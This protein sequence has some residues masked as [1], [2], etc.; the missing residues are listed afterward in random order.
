MVLDPKDREAVK[1][2]GLSPEIMESRYMRAQSLMQGL[3]SKTIAFNT[4]IIPRWIDNSDYFWYEREFKD[5]REFRLVNA[6]N[7]SNKLAFDH[8]KLAASLADASGQ[9]IDPTD[10]PITKLLFSSSLQRLEFDAFNTRWTFDTQGSICQTK[11][12]YPTEWLIS[13][14]GK[15]AA[16]V[17]DCNIWIHVLETNEE[18]QITRDGIPLYC[19]GST[20]SAYG[21]AAYS[22]NID[23]VWS[24]DS[25]RLL[26]LQLDMRLVKNLPMI[27]YVPPDGSLRP[28]YSSGDRRM[29]FPGDDHID[30]YRILSIDVRS[31]EQQDAHYRHC[32]VFRN[33]M[34][35][36][37]YQHGWWSEDS[38]HA[39]FIDMERNGDHVVRL[40]EFD[41]FTGATRLVITEES[42]DT[43]FKLRLDSRTPILTR[44]LS[45][46]N[47]VVWYSERS[48]WAHL[49]L[50]DLKTGQLK[51]AITSGEWL[52]RDILHYDPVLRELII[53]TAGR[54]K[55]RHAY[56]RDICRVNVDTG[57]L[58][59]IVSTNHEY[60]VFDEHSE[61]AMNLAGTR[62]VWGGFGVSPSGAYI[63]TTRSRA[64]EI[65]VSLLLDRDGNELF[66]L[67]T[68]DVSCLPDG[69]QWPEP[70]KLLGA[71]N[72]TDI[73]G[74]IYRPSHFSPEQ[75]YPILD[76]SLTLKEG[77]F[78]PAGSFTNNTIAGFLYFSAAALAELG[79]IVVDIYGRGTS[80]RER[81]FSAECCPEL[82]SSS[83]QADRISAIKQ[84]AEN[85]PYMDIER[86]GAGGMV[87]TSGAISG[88]LGHPDFYKVGVTNGAVS[89]LRVKSAFWGESYG[90]LPAS[91]DKYKPAHTYAKNLKGK[92]LIM[93]GMMH[94]SVPVANAFRLIDALQLANKDFDMLLLPNEGYAMNSYAIRRCWDYFVKELLGVEPPTQFKLTTSIDIITAHF[95]K[96]TELSR[97]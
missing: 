75:S 74:V 34:G 48:G 58:I 36:F 2:E 18:R 17:R 67:E 49:Y 72:K 51:N 40:V 68:A 19:Y 91:L 1:L 62:D 84:L 44:P 88:L 5:G 81:T 65:P 76:V 39:Y 78:L 95:A 77:N 57:E 45:D 96:R 59:P 26:T 23:A 89:D 28:V 6:A 25:K 73:Y 46:S 54:E 97:D 70:V 27:Q 63:V 35:F 13:P 83:H 32:P 85:Y 52:V 60:L 3:F 4:T 69:W 71:D 79:F 31:C 41:S 37:I 94:A 42:P 47:D 53:Q 66:I 9:S 56:Y 43:C 14:D 8:K 29:A 33:A 82:P 7:G 22:Q 30:E 50:Y 86:V 10:L 93:H 11:K 21:N 16:F 90:D 20:P 24:P 55:K 15:N 80:C 87:S 64:D 61:Q 12:C 92:L 38:R